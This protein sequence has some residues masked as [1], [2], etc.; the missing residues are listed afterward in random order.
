MT[1]G[2]ERPDAEKGDQRSPDAMDSK[3]AG[4]R[5]ARFPGEQCGDDGRWGFSRNALVGAHRRAAAES[6][7]TLPL[8]SNAIS[9][10]WLG[11]ILKL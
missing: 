6:I 5:V 9:T 3:F 7:G 1:S 11:K 10:I 8:A 4:I 2:P